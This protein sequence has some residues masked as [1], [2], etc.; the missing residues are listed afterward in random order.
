VT[1]F[2]RRYTLASYLVALMFI[3]NP[4]VDAS[5]NAWP[6]DF[7]NVQWRFGSTGIMSG[8]FISMLFGLL[9]LSAVAVAQQHRRVL[10]AVSAIC[11]LTALLLLL[12]SVTYTLDVLQ[13]HPMV[14]EDQAQMF[15]IGSLKTAFK[16][17]GSVLCAIALTLASFKSAKD[18]AEND[19]QLRNR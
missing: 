4:I 11:G 16:I 8:Y 6:W 14:R 12:A 5:T 10:Y 19:T 15:K 17:G 2:L 13:V 7:G 18:I 1:D 3:I 9:L